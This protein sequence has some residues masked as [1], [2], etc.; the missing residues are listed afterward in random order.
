MRKVP[1]DCTILTLKTYKK[2]KRKANKQRAK[3]TQNTEFGPNIAKSN[4]S[5][6]S[7]KQRENHRKKKRAASLTAPAKKKKRTFDVHL[8]REL[9]EAHSNLL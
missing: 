6:D 9:K 8:E 4:A 5:S 1:A 3:T 7:S 2:R